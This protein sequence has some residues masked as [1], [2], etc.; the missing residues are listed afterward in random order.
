MNLIVEMLTNNRCYKTETNIVPKGIM[1]HSVGCAQPNPDVFKKKWN[2]N[3][4]P[5][6]VHGIIG[7]DKCYQ[8]M[9]WNKRGWHAGV[10]YKN[11]PSAN[12]THIGV[13]MT[14]PSTIKYIGG[15]S[16]ID[17]NPDSSAAHVRKCYENAVAYFTYLCLKFNFNPMTDIISHAEGH[18]KKIASNHGDP[19][20]LWKK[21]PNLGYTMDGFRKDVL[22]AM[23]GTGD[24]PSTFA[25]EATR[26]AIK[27][28]IFNGDGDGN[29]DWQLPLTRE[30]AAVILYRLYNNKGVSG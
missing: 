17:L 27:E 29:Y 10:A 19:T 18:A 2:S 23:T 24:N 13:E 3:S 26:W 12:D 21:Y 14:E 6:G 16:F 4:C 5:I 7:A 8:F 1:L 9:P 15:A 28:G 11:G 20:H 22:E 30:Q 25:K